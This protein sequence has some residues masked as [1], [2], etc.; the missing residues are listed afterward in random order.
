[1]VSALS[2]RLL[3]TTPPTSE[4]GDNN[5]TKTEIESGYS[6]DRESPCDSP[7]QTASGGGFLLDLVRSSN[8]RGGHD[9]DT[10]IK[11]QKLSERHFIASNVKHDLA[12]AGRP[13]PSL[14]TSRSRIIP[15]LNMS[16]VQVISSKSVSDSPFLY[17]N[18]Q[19]TKSD[20]CCDSFADVGSAYQKLIRETS[21]A[22]N[23]RTPNGYI[24][25]SSQ[26][27]RSFGEMDKK[28]GYTTKKKSETLTNNCIRD[29]ANGQNYIDHESI[30]EG[31]GAIIVVG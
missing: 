29:A 7:R 11:R 25:T 23:I 24:T 17:T 21:F 8:K 12:K 20:G 27:K 5:T 31:Y 2:L 28:G 30:N 26:S 18:E 4:N 19:L 10:R 3:K 6:A 22:Y 9:E 14:V 13:Y 15:N 16:G 1:M